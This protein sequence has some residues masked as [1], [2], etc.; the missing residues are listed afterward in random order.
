M[1]A[2]QYRC[3]AGFFLCAAV[4]W[5]SA[6][7]L[8]RAEAA[9]KAQQWKRAE[10]DLE[11]LL[12]QAPHAA[13]AEE[14][15]VLLIDVAL[16][17]ENT[18]FAEAT[19]Q[20]FKR[21][22]G[23][24]PHLARVLYY[25]GIL[26]LQKGRNGDAA[27]AFAAAL[28]QARVQGV[29]DAASLALRRLVDARGLL[30][31]ELE[32]TWKTLQRDPVLGP[33]LLER[34]GD[35][36]ERVGRHRA[37]EAAYTQ[38]LESYPD[39]AGA[40]RVR[41]K[42]ARAQAA[43]EESPVVLLMA[44]FSGEFSEVGR[45]LRE[46]ATLAFED[47]QRRGVSL[48]VLETLDDQGNLIYGV[49]TFRKTLREERIGAVIGPAMS[50]VATG[51]AI[52]LSARKSSIPLIT[53]TATTYGIASL[54]EGVFQLNVTT[55][56]L[57]QRIA[58]FASDCLG[59]KDFIIVAPHNEYGF[60]LS[61]V[62]AKTVEKK[63]GTVVSV[64][65]VDPDATDL[66]D[67]LQDVRQKLAK[68]FFDQMKWEGQPLPDAHA[69]RSW[70]S[71]STFP[72]DG[73]FIPA[74]SADEANKLASQVIFNKISGQMLGSSGWFDK[75]LL[76]KN[77]EATHGAYFSVDFP[78]QPKTQIY[79][80][81]SQAYRNRWKRSPDRVAALSYD[82]ARFLLAGMSQ[83]SPP[84]QLIRALRAIRTFPG[85]LGDIEFGEDEGVN[86]NTA[87]YH[88]E[89]KAFKEVNDCPDSAAAVKAP[90]R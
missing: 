55:H 35:E 16:Q 7:S 8:Q 60:Q 64:T 63:G 66:S 29:Y 51:V 42:L 22:Y 5:A 38:Y 83:A 47:A 34:L 58:A 53:P 10:S 23:A 46:G 77:S 9:V 76:L 13:V 78:D 67:P 40:E 68:I 75:T 21:Q 6:A 65:Y 69:L 39:V 20:R 73:I 79:S 44:P 26:A 57:G 56:T 84:D 37:A 33:G 89:R 31:D 24:S 15:T 25:Q 30:P 17:Q 85:V 80:D 74:T 3:A 72:V 70:M 19:V 14:A 1:T 62:F 48:P 88:F 12:R 90:V 59:L 32:A 2:A 54:G 4:G 27:Q 43:P 87:V 41:D 81:F 50:D 49:Q 28:M 86:E 18:D 61:E 82:A 11:Q 52:E 36:R 71:D 45:S